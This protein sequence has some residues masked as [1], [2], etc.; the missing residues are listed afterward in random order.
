MCAA[1]VSICLPTDTLVGI[2]ADMW[3][4]CRQDVPRY[5]LTHNKMIIFPA[6][7]RLVRWDMYLH[8]YGQVFAHARMHLLKHFCNSVDIR[9]EIFKS[10]S[11]TYVP[12]LTIKA[13]NCHLD[14]H[15]WSH[16]IKQSLTDRR[17]ANK[18]TFDY[19]RYWL[20]TYVCTHVCNVM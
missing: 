16:K 18:Q 14:Q 2:C 3:L 4:T 13:H 1:D 12:T 7:T 15:M 9:A 8:I 20:S 11:P 10:C 17:F 19:H 6:V 5:V